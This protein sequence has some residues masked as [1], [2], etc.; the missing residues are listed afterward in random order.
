MSVVNQEADGDQRVTTLPVTITIAPVSNGPGDGITAWSPAVTVTEGNDVPLA[1]I[2]SAIQLGDGSTIASNGPEIIESVSVDFTNLL[3]SP[4]LIPGITSFAQLFT[5]AYIAGIGAPG[6]TVNTTT[7]VVSGAPAL[8]AALSIRAAALIDSNIDFSL[9][10]SAVTRDPGAAAT[11][12]ASATFTVDMVGDADT[13]TSTAPSS[14]S[15]VAG[16][17]IALPIGNS[18]AISAARRQIRMPGKAAVILSRS[19]TSSPHADGGGKLGFVDS[20]GNLVGSNLGNGS[21]YLT[22]A[23]LATP[24]GLFLASTPSVSASTTVLTWRTV[25]VENDGDLAFADA[26]T[27]ISVSLA[28]TGSGGSGTPPNPPI[29]NISPPTAQEDG[30]INLGVTATGDPGDTVVVVLTA[31]PPARDHTIP[32]R[33]ATAMETTFYRLSAAR[34]LLPSRSVGC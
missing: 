4:G 31:L 6:L 3:N 10:V 2:V 18:A 28:P 17:P 23:D 21:W 5:T 30:L 25:A 1:N 9:G 11:S 32:A 33:S 19:T 16:T 27:T 8:I 14:L 12:S 22:P 20:G 13:P 7:G 26:P 34:F 24:G 29:V 15:G